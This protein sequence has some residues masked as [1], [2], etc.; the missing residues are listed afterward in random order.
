MEENCH[1]A[2][3]ALSK[4]KLEAKTKK[5][6]AKYQYDVNVAQSEYDTTLAQL[7]ASVDMAR[8]QMES[9]ANKIAEYQKKL[10]KGEKCGAALAEEQANYSSLAAKLQSE[11]NTQAVKSVE[12]KQKYEEDLLNRE[13]F[14]GDVTDVYQDMTGNVT[15]IASKAENVCYVSRKAVILEEGRSYLKV[16]REDGT[17]EM[18]EVMTGLSDGVNIEIKDGAEEGSVALIESQVRAE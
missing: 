10:A 14:T 18:T 8:T 3:L 7:Q 5:L 2:E 12:A 6:N 11:L 17:I 1:L 9:S 16:K 13:L 4:A 15:F